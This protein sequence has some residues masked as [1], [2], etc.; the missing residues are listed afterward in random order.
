M[1]ISTRQMVIV[2]IFTSLT[3]G[4]SVFTRF[5]AGIIP[6]S[7]LPL[8]VMLA[9]NILGSRLG[10]LSMLLYLVLGLLGIPVFASPPYGGVAYVFQPSFGFLIGFIFG[11]YVVGKITEIGQRK[12]STYFIA[13]IIGILVINLFGLTYFWFLFSFV[14]KQPKPV[15]EILNVGVL[16]FIFPDLIK[17]V[18]A[19]FLSFNINKR[20]QLY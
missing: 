3:V 12:Q 14:L 17:G 15:L 7:L 4:I 6:F 16:P 10:A 2:S 9:G 11:A 8:M 5:S 19:S 20:V 18:V 13:N 1:N